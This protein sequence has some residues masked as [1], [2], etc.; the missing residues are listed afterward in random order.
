MKKADHHQAGCCCCCSTSSPP[1]RAPPS[2]VDLMTPSHNREFGGSSIF[3]T[4]PL[5]FFYW[6]PPPPHRLYL[7]LS[8]LIPPISFLLF[9]KA[10]PWKFDILILSMICRSSGS[11]YIPETFIM[12]L[13]SSLLLWWWKLGQS[14]PTR[15]TIVLVLQNK[16]V[17]VLS[18][19]AISRSL[20]SRRPP[21]CC[22]PHT[23]GCR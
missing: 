8:T 13:T 19:S 22:T 6:S 17:Q 14:R 2:Q 3:G 21:R 1:P 4:S 16:A 11:L 18:I 10:G 23:K 5:L 20:Q 12:Y 7:V 9:T 15:R